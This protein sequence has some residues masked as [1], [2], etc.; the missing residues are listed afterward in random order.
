MRISPDGKE[1]RIS[2]TDLMLGALIL[3]IHPSLPIKVVAKQN[4]Q[5][6]VIILAE[7]GVDV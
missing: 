3:Q 7:E 1:I 4:K 6:L 5:G 2:P